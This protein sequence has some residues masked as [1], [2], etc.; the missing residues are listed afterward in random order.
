M[1]SAQASCD[2]WAIMKKFIYVCN[3]KH[4]IFACLL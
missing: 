3:D 4:Y 2:A 1:R